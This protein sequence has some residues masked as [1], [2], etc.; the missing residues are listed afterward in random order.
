MFGNKITYEK[1]IR[2]ALAKSQCAI[3]MTHWKEY[4]KINDNMINKMRKKIII[5]SRRILSE[6]EINADYHAIGI[7]KNK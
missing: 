2:D 7:G 3:I 1:T 6:K 5:D 4:S